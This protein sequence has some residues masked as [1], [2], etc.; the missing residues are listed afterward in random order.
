MSNVGVRNS[1][2]EVVRVRAG[3]REHSDL[4][5]LITEYV[6]T[7]AGKREPTG[8]V[9]WEILNE[10]TRVPTP[11]LAAWVTYIDGTA[12]GCVLAVEGPAGMIE[13]SRLFVRP[14]YRRRG[15][16]RS[17]VARLVDWVGSRS[18]VYLFVQTKRKPAIS[19]YRKFGFMECV[20]APRE[21]FTEMVRG[22]T[23]AE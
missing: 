19:L 23:P 5:G 15:V 14:E 22:G 10:L 11:Y 1:T 16:A 3:G 4:V 8:A 18:A 7:W 17:L 12:A 2:I 20:V 9:E 21:K 13:L 6:T